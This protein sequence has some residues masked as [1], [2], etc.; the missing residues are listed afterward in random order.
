VALQVPQELS[1]LAIFLFLVWL[2]YP[3]IWMLGQGIGYLCVGPE[4]SFFAF[5]DLFTKVCNASQKNDTT[6]NKGNTLQVGG[7]LYVLYYRRQL[8]GFS[9][10][11]GTDRVMKFDVPERAV[12]SIPG[13]LE[14]MHPKTKALV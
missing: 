4:Q 9:T 1:I 11:N 6:N 13:P 3:I 2:Q 14:K 10:T 7:F 5:L 8:N 12:V